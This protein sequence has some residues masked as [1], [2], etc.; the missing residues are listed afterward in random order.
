MKRSLSRLLVGLL[1]APLLACASSKPAPPVPE[2]PPTYAARVAERVAIASEQT[3][4]VVRFNSVPCG[5]PPFEVK[6]GAV[7]QRVR[8]DVSADAETEVAR[9]LRDALS[10]ADG[11]ALYDVEGSLGSGLAACARGALYVTISPQVFARAHPDD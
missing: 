9:A 8:F 3:A 6:L 11:T 4:F 2:P 7:G 5:C 10:D 1:A